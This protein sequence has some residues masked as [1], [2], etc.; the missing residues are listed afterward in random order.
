M[1]GKIRAA[2]K[3]NRNG[4]DEFRSTRWLALSGLDRMEPDNAIVATTR[5]S[6]LLALKSIL[7]EFYFFLLEVIVSENQVCSEGNT[8]CKARLRARSP[9]YSA[10]KLT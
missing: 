6:K 8:G 2:S 10:P 3:E 1:L 7:Y 9:N 5:A 4:R